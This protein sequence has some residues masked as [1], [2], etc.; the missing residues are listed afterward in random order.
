[1]R[2]MAIYCTKYK[3]KEWPVVK[4]YLLSHVQNPRVIM[5]A[6]P[7]SVIRRLLEDSGVIMVANHTDNPD[8]FKY[9]FWIEDDDKFFMWLIKTGL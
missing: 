4:S 5:G 7:I 2:P 1:M 6:D 3:S 9:D 8:L